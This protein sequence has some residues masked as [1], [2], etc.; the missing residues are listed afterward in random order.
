[1][2]QR[3]GGRFSIIGWCKRPTQA[4]RWNLCGGGWG[5]DGWKSFFFYLSYILLI[6]L[7]RE[8]VAS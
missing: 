3:C 8:G 1:M 5:G 6:F 4:F 2:I 7:D